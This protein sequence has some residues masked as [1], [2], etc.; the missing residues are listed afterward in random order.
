MPSA[1]LLPLS[2]QVN[3]NLGDYKL[4]LRTLWRS[5]GETA[6]ALRSRGFGPVRHRPLYH[7]PACTQFYSLIDSH[8]E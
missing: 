6:D 2:Y 5:Q 3:A 7:C 8:P 4:G 1:S